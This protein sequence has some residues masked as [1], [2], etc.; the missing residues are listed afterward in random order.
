MLMERY[1]Q[2][3]LGITATPAEYL[4]V[5]E[6]ANQRRGLIPNGIGEDAL[7]QRQTVLQVERSNFSVP[8][9]LKLSQIQYFPKL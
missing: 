6:F 7:L 3:F 9:N 2:M 4:S 8:R 1:F 5:L